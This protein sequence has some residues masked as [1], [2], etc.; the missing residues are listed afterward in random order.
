VAGAH[1]EHVSVCPL[2]GAPSR[3]PVPWSF[4]GGDKRC[5]ACIYRGLAEHLPRAHSENWSWATAPTHLRAIYDQAKAWVEDWREEAAT[6]LF[7][8]GPPGVGKTGLA[9]CVARDDLEHGGN[10]AFV[11]VRRLLA[12][13]RERISAERANELDPSAPALGP[14]PRE[15][16]CDEYELVVLD[17]LAAERSTAWRLDELALIIEQRCDTGRGGLV[18]TANYGPADLALRLGSRR[19]AVAGE[20]LVSRILHGATCIEIEGADLRLRDGP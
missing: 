5:Y 4:S 14:D 1:Y 3:H 11:N 7:I 10:P 13:L 16:L 6:N 12:E 9:W 19:D 18:V 20:R 15:R 17:D 8:Y 2:C